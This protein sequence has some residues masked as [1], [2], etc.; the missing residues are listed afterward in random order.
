MPFDQPREVA[1]LITER[2]EAL[3][4]AREADRKLRGLLKEIEQ[5]TFLGEGI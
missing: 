1:A 3:I 2:A 4:K 5:K